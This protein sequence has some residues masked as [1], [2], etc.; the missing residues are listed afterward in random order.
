[1]LFP[2]EIYD[3]DV[4]TLEEKTEELEKAIK[5]SAGSC[6]KQW[7]HTLELA[8]LEIEE[9][10]SIEQFGLDLEHEIQLFD[11]Y[12]MYPVTVDEATETRL[13]VSLPDNKEVRP[14]EL[15]E[16]SRT[17]VPRPHKK[18]DCS[19]L[20]V[21]KR[22]KINTGAL[23]I[24]KGTATP[25][26]NHPFKK[27]SYR[28]EARTEHEG[29]PSRASIR[30]RASSQRKI[31]PLAPHDIRQK[32]TIATDNLRSKRP[33]VSKVVTEGS[34]KS[35]PTIQL[36]TISKQEEHVSIKNEI[37]L[38]QS[39]VESP[40]LDK[41]RSISEKKPLPVKNNIKFIENDI[42]SDSEE[43]DH[44]TWREPAPLIITALKE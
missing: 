16:S 35:S 21:L 5:Q 37:E 14:R 42:Y 36:R 17:I 40:L 4:I 32:T 18:V 19:I 43:E 27:K 7:I 22:T 20:E 39:Q 1:M 3:L 10:R 24:G 29:R 15:T 28:E 8:K 31:P 33:T 26:V 12:C 41:K 44:S 30:E 9:R 25:V 6:P 13:P 34:N 38:K 2:E 11:R 23:V